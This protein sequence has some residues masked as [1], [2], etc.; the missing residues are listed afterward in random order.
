MNDDA[1]EIAER[2]E[3]LYQMNEAERQGV[4]RGLRAMREGRFASNE[5]MAAMFEKARS[6]RL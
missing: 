2:H 3:G 4:E 5:R 6:S 1:R